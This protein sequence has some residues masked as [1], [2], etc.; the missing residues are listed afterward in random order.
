MLLVG[1]LFR[2][3]RTS[4]RVVARERGHDG[5]CGGEDGVLGRGEEHARET[6]FHG[7]LREF[8]SGI[9]ECGAAFGGVFDGAELEQFAE[10]FADHGGFGRVDEG[11]LLDVAEAEVEHRE[12]HAGE[13][14]TQNLGRRVGV[15]GVEI[16]FGVEA[17]ASAGAETSATSRA[18][19]GGGLRDGF[20]LE[21]LHLRAVDVARDAREAGVDYGADAGNGDGCLGHVRGEDDAAALGQSKGALLFAGGKGGEE[22]DDVVLAVPHARE[23]VGRLADVAFAGEEHEDVVG[24][25]QFGDGGGD[26]AREVEFLAVLWR[27]VAELNGVETGAP[28]KKAAKL[29]VSSVA[30]ETTTFRSRR[31][32]RTRLRMPRRKSMLRERSWASSTMMQS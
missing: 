28:L 2:V 20:D 19:S 16:L 29:A 13:G 7:D 30:D 8:A 32:A 27:T 9:R 5:D 18:L 4:A 22:G 6:G 1:L 23:V 14:G 17:D 25:G 11:E 12:D 15:A 3:D 10:T 21:T 24:R 26:V 31:R